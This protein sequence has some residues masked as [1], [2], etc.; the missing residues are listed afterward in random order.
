MD[1]INP[2]SWDESLNLSHD[3]EAPYNDPSDD[4]KPLNSSDNDDIG[5]TDSIDDELEEALLGDIT[6]EDLMLVMDG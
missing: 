4:D 2:Y 6:V 3:L 5:T 1:G